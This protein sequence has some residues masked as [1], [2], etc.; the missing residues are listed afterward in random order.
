MMLNVNIGYYKK[1]DWNRY[2]EIMEDKGKLH[3]S[4]YAWNMDF[5][6][7]KKKLRKQGIRVNEVIVNLDELV[8]FCKEKE[9]IIDGKARSMFVQQK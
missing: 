3:D 5:K 7:A 2:K 6:K 8:K 1:E 4:W 9:L